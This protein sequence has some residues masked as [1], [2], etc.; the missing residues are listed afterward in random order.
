MKKI[1]QMIWK[2]VNMGIIL[3]WVAKENINKETAFGLINE[4]NQSEP[5]QKHPKQKEQV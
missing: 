1:K 5:G 2:K 3:H 4:K